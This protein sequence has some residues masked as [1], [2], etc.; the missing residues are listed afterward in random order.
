MIRAND[1][2]IGNIVYGV[3]DRLEIIL[4]I[5]N[6]TIATTSLIHI[7]SPFEH[8]IEDLSE[9][10]L[11]EDIILKLGFKSIPHF[12]VTNSYTFDLGMGRQ[13]SIGCVGTPNEML[14]IQ[15][16]DFEVS[17]QV[18]DIICLHNFDYDG[19]LYLHKLQNIVAIF[20]QELK[21]TGL[22]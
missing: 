12:T 14:F 3:S 8:F 7:D 13:I 1:L 18:T 21:T 20:G 10:D 6:A 15:E 11:T 5:N 9:V 22:I 19:K 16:I 2:R 17:N 4:G